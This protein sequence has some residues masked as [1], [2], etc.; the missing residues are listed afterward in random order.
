MNKAL[1][2]PTQNQKLFNEPYK[3]GWRG[4]G[5]CEWRQ[6]RDRQTDILRISRA[7]SSFFFFYFPL[8]IHI[9]ISPPMCHQDFM[10]P[11]C[12]LFL[13]FPS[14]HFMFVS[15]DLGSERGAH[16]SYI[17]KPP[18]S[19]SVVTRAA[20]HSQTLPICSASSLLPFTTCA[21]LILIWTKH[22]KLCRWPHE[23]DDFNL[24]VTF[25]YIPR[26]HFLLEH[27]SF[28]RASVMKLARVDINLCNT[29]SFGMSILRSWR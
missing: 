2:I 21:N 6:E 19:C 14:A 28:F 20:D 4:G 7:S 10:V 3:K 29:A 27:G 15:I 25:A 9:T 16:L 23:H 12:S 17:W 13:H 26:P 18:W 24:L 8:S 1:K 5:G 11:L 22:K